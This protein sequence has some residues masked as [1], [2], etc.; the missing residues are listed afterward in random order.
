[1][2][3]RNFVLKIISTFFYI[4]YLPF[5]PGTF[6]SVVGLFLF[7][8][9]KDSVLVY[10]SLTLILVVLGFWVSSKAEKIFQKKDPRYIVIDEVAGMFFS[11]MFIP[12]DLKLFIA[13]FVLFRILDALKPYPADTLQRLKGGV[14]IMTDDIIAGLYTNL[15]LQVTLRLIS[16][17]AS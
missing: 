3:P 11:L 17:R 7:F 10:L 16:L 4:G 12:Y 2:N 8:L 13:A 5:I 6:A 15:I 14:G 9:V 1:M